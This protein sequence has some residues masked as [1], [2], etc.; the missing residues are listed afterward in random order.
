M[1]HSL[2]DHEHIR[3]LV[4]ASLQPRFGGPVSWRFRRPD[5]SIAPRK[6][7]TR[8]DRELGLL[9]A[10]QTQQTFDEY[11]GSDDDHAPYVHGAPVHDRW[12][13]LEVLKALQHYSY[14]AFDENIDTETNEAVRYC[15]ALST[16][17]IQ[18]LLGTD[19]PAD[20]IR[21]LTTTPEWE[22]GPLEINAEAVPAAGPRSTAP[23]RRPKPRTLTSLQRPDG[24]VRPRARS[25]RPTNPVP[26]VMPAADQVWAWEPGRGPIRLTDLDQPLGWHH[27]GHT[28]SPD[29]TT[30]RYLA[31]SSNLDRPPDELRTLDLRTGETTAEPPHRNH[32]RQVP[33]TEGT[34]ALVEYTDIVE[35]SLTR[36]LV[37]V[38]HRGVW[39]RLDSRAPDLGVAATG[40]LLA[41]SPSGDLLAVTW[42]WG[43]NPFPMTEVVDLRDGDDTSMRWAVDLHGQAPWNA[44]GSRLLVGE[45]QTDGYISRVVSVWDRWQRS[46]EPVAVL[47]EHRGQD[48]EHLSWVDDR[49]LLSMVTEGRQVSMRSVDPQTGEQEEYATF[50]RP[51]NR[52]D[53]HTILVA[54]GVVQGDPETLRT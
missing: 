25:G 4:W 15:A 37:H 19:P 11:H 21:A 17:L 54:P 16:A 42:R 27:E 47:P 13:A 43:H 36:P 6:A 10:A 41:F 30:I 20:E 34:E 49:R 51:V 33:Y 35:Y 31:R 8:S 23:R 44:D 48:V 32:V 45:T 53:M 2:V 18:S 9:L 22:A 5:G 7:S 29:G 38:Q 39:R 24:P 12:S 50:R 52:G 3:V 26:W 14:H 1:S 28:L 46:V 40:T